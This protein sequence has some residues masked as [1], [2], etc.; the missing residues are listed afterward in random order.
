[1]YL[2]TSNLLSEISF[3]VK[4][5]SKLFS[6]NLVH[7]HYNK[8]YHYQSILQSVYNL[9]EIHILNYFIIFMF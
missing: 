2:I 6:R 9:E 1:M 8:I 4:Y 3:D 5:P 7:I